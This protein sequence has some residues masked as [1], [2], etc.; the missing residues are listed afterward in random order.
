MLT[1]MP[2]ELILDFGCGTTTRSAWPEVIIFFTSGTCII[3]KDIRKEEVVINACSTMDLSR[4]AHLGVMQQP[5]I[6]DV[7]PVES[8]EVGAEA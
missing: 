4:E 1:I 3:G 7:R 6:G 5:L 2:F 8:S